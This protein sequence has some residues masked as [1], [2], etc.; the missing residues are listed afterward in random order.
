[1][2]NKTQQ[3][4]DGNV[5]SFSKNMDN[6]NQRFY[7]DTQEWSYARNAS[8]FSQRGDIGDISNEKSNMMMAA[9]PYPII[10]AIHIQD[11]VWCIFS[12][13]RRYPEDEGKCEI[14]LFNESLSSYETKISN[15]EC[16]CLN[17]DLEHLVKGAA[18]I[19]G[20]CHRVVYWD[21]GINVSRRLDIDDIPW[22]QR[23]RDNMNEECRETVADESV[24]DSGHKVLDCDKIRLSPVFKDLS[25]KCTSADSSG[26]IPNGSYFVYGKYVIDG[27]EIGNTSLPS[28][29]VT[30]FDHRGAAGSIDIEITEADDEFKE[31]N[32]YICMFRFSNTAAKKLGTYSTHQKHIVIDTIPESLPT[33]DYGD[34]F[35]NIEIPHHSEALVRFDNHLMRLAPTMKFKFNYQPQANRIQ[36][37]WVVVEHDMD[38]YRNGGLDVGYMRDEVYSFFIRFIYNTGDKSDSYHIPGRAIEDGEDTPMASGDTLFE[39]EPKWQVYNTAYLERDQFNGD[40]YIDKFGNPTSEQT[41]YGKI[42]AAGKMGYWESSEHYPDDSYERWGELCGKPIR[43]HKFPS[44]VLN[45]GTSNATDTTNHYAD[46]GGKIRVLGV[47][48]TGIEYPRMFNDSEHPTNPPV[49]GIVGYEILRGDRMGNKTVLAKGLLNNMREYWK[50]ENE[51]QASTHVDEN[52]ADE[53]T[54]YYY[55]NY[56]YNPH[57]KGNNVD[58]FL[59]ETLSKNIAQPL[60]LQNLRMLSSLL[61][62]GTSELHNDVLMGE[63]HGDTNISSKMYTFHSPDTSFKHPFLNPKELKIYGN[64][65]GKSEGFFRVPEKHP[66]NKLITDKAFTVA[67]ILSF[68]HAIE[69]LEG[70]V[71]EINENATIDY[72]GTTAGGGTAVSTTGLFG[73]SAP[74]SIVQIFAHL[75]KAIVK[76]TLNSLMDSPLGF[77]VIGLSSQEVKGDMNEIV[78]GTAAATG[79][80]G[81]HNSTQVEKSAWQRMPF[82]MRLMTGL[83]SFAI[84]WGE[85]IDDVLDIIY[86]FSP[87]R[88]Y[89]LQFV[90]HGFYDKFRNQEQ[91]QIRRKIDDLMYMTPTMCGLGSKR[92]INNMF[93][94]ESVA[95]GLTDDLFAPERKDTSQYTYT[96]EYRGIDILNTQNEN[97]HLYGKTS[98]SKKDISS[99]YGALKQRLVNQYGQIDSIIQV[100]I[101]TDWRE[102]TIDNNSGNPVT[103]PVLF[104]GDTYIGRYTEKNTMPFFYEWLDGQPDGTEFNY[105]QYVNIPLPRF[106]MDTE[107]YDISEVFE[108]ISDDNGSTGIDIF[109]CANNANA[110]S[111]SSD[112]DCNC[113]YKFEASNDETNGFSGGLAYLGSSIFKD[114][115]FFKIFGPD[116]LPTPIHFESDEDNQYNNEDDCYYKQK[117]DKL[118]KQYKELYIKL[119]KQQ[120]AID[121]LES[122]ADYFAGDGRIDQSSRNYNGADVDENNQSRDREGGEPNPF[123]PCDFEDSEGGWQ[124]VGLLKNI[125]SIQLETV[126]ASSNNADNSIAITSVTCGSTIIPFNSSDVNLNNKYLWDKSFFPKSFWS[127][128]G[129]GVRSW[130]TDTTNGMY[131]DKYIEE[132]KGKYHK[133]IKRMKRKVEHLNKKLN[134]VSEKLNK[135]KGGKKKKSLLDRL[136]FP[137]GKFYLDGYSNEPANIFMGMR[138]MVGVK[139]AYMYL[140]NSGVMDFFVESDVNIDFRD[141]DDTPN[142]RHYDHKLYTDLDEMFKPKYIRDGNKYKY[143][144]SLSA[145]KF[146][147][148]NSISYAFIQKRDYN[149]DTYLNCYT[150]IPQRLLYSLPIN[151]QDSH[152]IADYW[153]IFLPLNFR[154]FT[155]ELINLK[156]IGNNAFML[157]LRNDAPVLVSNTMTLQTT[158]G[159]SITVGDGSMFNQDPKPLL[160]TDAVHE[161]GACQNFYSVIYT[162]VGIFWVGQNQNKIYT[163]A[164]NVTPISNGMMKSWF[165]Q[166]TKFKI[167]DDFPEFELTDNPV[168]GCG[169]QSV[170]DNE[171]NIVYFCKRDYA[172]N[173]YGRELLRSGSIRHIEGSRFMVDKDKIIYL[174]DKTYF[175]DASWTISYSPMVQSFISFHDWKPRLTMGS[176]TTFLTTEGL[177]KPK[178]KMSPDEAEMY[179]GTNGLRG[180]SDRNIIW[181]HNERTDSFCNY[182]GEDFPFEIEI[183][184]VTKGNVTTLKNIVYFMEV[185]VYGDNKYDRYHVLDFNFDEAIVYN[186]EQ[187]SGLLKLNLKKKNDPRCLI[188]FPKIHDDCI[189]IL[190]S[191]EEHKYKF[192]QFFDIVKDRGEF[193]SYVSETLEQGNEAV[194]EFNN[195]I[196]KPIFK[197]NPNGYVKEL[198][199]DALDYHKKSFEH[200]KFRHYK[201]C[202]ILR[203][204]KSG[205][206]NMVISLVNNVELNSF[207]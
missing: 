46:G 11:G 30:L 58:K 152:S 178:D 25:F 61:N 22:K 190:F 118:F 121:F 159:S 2:A 93:R 108:G 18:R 192:D 139:N 26:D 57:G 206:R 103:S 24:D 162:P 173:K 140:F 146:L 56:P 53:I 161:R 40:W 164:D 158:T 6:D 186:S 85:G 110:S 60:W 70:K 194:D 135:E 170:F 36:A 4:I 13:T 10:G 82:I 12:T 205:N 8:V 87:Y 175:D 133:V 155:S 83:S 104:G 51:I 181:K 47:Y 191:K 107:K 43:H 129:D 66:K 14:G 74:A 207:R 38:Y 138:G 67:M 120:Q 77:N 71:I 168:A 143:D 117:S 101:S 63:G 81:G 198:N 86:K 29:I 20:K 97:L 203:R 119:L 156:D 54:R 145:G 3:N 150:K 80:P 177:L 169:F 50:K 44:N 182:Y 21:D 160:T 109:K 98:V 78:E 31:L 204:L 114:I 128:S 64:I 113:G 176:R 147:A 111:D 52:D 62:I 92:V 16:E 28:N 166:Y 201:N 68:G 100:P 179:Y 1:M 15:E 136:K 165:D 32:L 134:K 76:K 42:V 73:L 154:D 35:Q 151:K 153:R 17:F 163:S 116:L 9:A 200:K 188:T 202:V 89:A 88:Q 197:Y 19:D 27:M 141:W 79:A 55:A 84:Y 171:S 59:V 48:F 185:Y 187:C 149:I 115:D 148:R 142:G 33:A 122:C 126:S 65:Y 39:R 49:D 45:E 172:L 91:S 132:D 5:N 199:E 72:G 123:F 99:Y 167:L 106:W 127:I 184:F 130:V 137:S 75:G 37:H 174:G 69:R 105:L 180:D 189:D 183:P 124:F 96:E 157:F 112:G 196:V 34:I 23:L 41:N 90:S 102:I 95:I 7:H 131:S 125:T 193:S 144:Y 94:T 195:E